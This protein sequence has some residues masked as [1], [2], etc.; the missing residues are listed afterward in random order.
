MHVLILA[1][2]RWIIKTK[3]AYLF[4][5]LLN[6]FLIV[7]IERFWEKKSGGGGLVALRVFGY[8]KRQLELL[9]FYECLLVKDIRNLQISLR[10]ELLYSH[11]F[12]TYMN[13][14]VLVNTSLF[15]LKLKCCPNFL[16]MTQNMKFGLCKYIQ[17]IIKS[18]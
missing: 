13:G 15:T 12:I 14:L 4:I 5:F 7:L 17:I 9:G 6:S 16:W 3:F 2:R 18:L 8:L 1:P 10:N 11:V